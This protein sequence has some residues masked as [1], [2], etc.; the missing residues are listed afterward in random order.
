MP[1]S[2]EAAGSACGVLKNALVERQ[3]A[4]WLDNR[5]SPADRER[6]LALLSELGAGPGALTR[7]SAG[8]AKA[9]ARPASAPV[10]GKKSWVYTATRGALQASRERP[11]QGAGQRPGTALGSSGRR[12]QTASPGSRAPHG[13]AAAPH[14]RRPAS[15]AN[16]G[17]GQQVPAVH[18][19][20]VSLQAPP[21]QQQQTRA[22]ESHQQQHTQQQALHLGPMDFTISRSTYGLSELYPDLYQEVSRWS[23][24]PGPCPAAGQGRS[25]H[26]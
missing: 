19:T 6:C 23:R 24:L 16:V 7:G 18:G 22:L 5:A 17:Q 12:P 13:E 11:A 8:G 21:Q 25:S 26:G 15:A 1:P 20:R 4:D 10:A 2:R 9:P 3:L 14:G